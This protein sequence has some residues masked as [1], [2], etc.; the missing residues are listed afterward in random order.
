MD[1]VGDKW[2]LRGP[3]LVNAAIY[4]EIAAARICCSR[5]LFRVPNNGLW[6]GSAVSVHLVDPYP[7]GLCLCHDLVQL[8]LH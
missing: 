1:S 2:I 7:F 8:D 5:G 3:R 6:V 4:R